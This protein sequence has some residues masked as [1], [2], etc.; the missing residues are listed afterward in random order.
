MPNR[1]PHSPGDGA[2]PETPDELLDCRV[3]MLGLDLSAVAD[4]G[5]ALQEIMRKC[6]IC[7][8]REACVADLKRD[9]NDPVWETYCPNAKALL[10]L[11]ESSW[12]TR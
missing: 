11:A 1:N 10:G 8:Y 2:K 12:T 7:G 5:N 9:P 3:E 4:A 6:P